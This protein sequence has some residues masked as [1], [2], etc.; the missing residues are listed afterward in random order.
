MEK[1]WNENEKLLD[2]LKRGVPLSGNSN[3]FLG[4]DLNSN[5]SLEYDNV[6]RVPVRLARHA[7]ICS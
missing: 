4:Y 1:L 2:I 5:G 6:I 7:T 3:N